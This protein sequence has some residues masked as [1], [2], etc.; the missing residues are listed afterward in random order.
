MCV[1]IEVIVNSHCIPS[2]SNPITSPPASKYSYVAQD[3][4]KNSCS[5]GTLVDT[6]AECKQAALALK[7]SSALRAVDSW[8]YI[9]KGCFFTGSSGSNV[10]F[11]THSTGSGHSMFSPVCKVKGTYIPHPPHEDAKQET[12]HHT[13]PHIHLCLILLY[14]VRHYKPRPPA[15]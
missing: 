7:G 6:E 13:S 10:Y 11:N 4:G 14:S 5:Q 12:H 2:Y 1:C 3:F 9:P 15:Q 8:S